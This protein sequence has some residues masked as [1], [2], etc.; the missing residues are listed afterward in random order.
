VAIAGRAFGKHG[1]PGALPH[2]FAHGGVDAQGVGTPP[3]FQEQGAGL[4]RKPARHGP[5]AHF[6]FGHKMHALRGVDEVNI[7]PRYVIADQQGAARV[8][9]RAF[10]PDLQTQH[11]EH[12]R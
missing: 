11:A 3:A 12:L 5:G 4:V 10:H 8:L 1:D 7:Q 2:Q 9:R 6:G